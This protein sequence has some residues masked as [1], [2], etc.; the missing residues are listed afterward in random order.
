M[1]NPIKL[2]NRKL[3]KLIALI[4]ALGFL[5]FGVY[6]TQKTATH[7]SLN[8]TNTYTVTQ[9]FDGDTIEV[10]MDGHKEKVRFIGV[11]TPETHDPRKAVQCFGRAA[12]NFTKQKLEKQTIR[13]EAD[14]I[15]TNR[16]RY[17]RL[18]RYVYTTQGE[19]INATLIKE[20]YG[21]AY[22]GFPF[23]KSD[24]FRQ[25]QVQARQQNKGLWADCKPTENQYNSFT[26]NN[27]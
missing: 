8:L 5:L 15:N 17:D 11:D 23:T 3:K 13:L 10:N 21:F 27:E 16:D 26:S 12:A 25:Y 7:S 2:G 18:L 9:V 20:G 22:L 6:S 1:S 19:L 14:P 4:V 24:E